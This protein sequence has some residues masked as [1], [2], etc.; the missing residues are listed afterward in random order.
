MVPRHRATIGASDEPL[1]IEPYQV[2]ADRRR[3]CANALHQFWYGHRFPLLHEF[4]APHARFGRERRA[5]II[6]LGIPPPRLANGFF[7]HGTCPLSRSP[8]FVRLV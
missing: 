8:S 2:T 1:L 3:R 6:A 4:D 5:I 7:S